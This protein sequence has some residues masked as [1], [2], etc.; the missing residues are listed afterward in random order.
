MVNTELIKEFK[1]ALLFI[2]KFVGLYILLNLAYGIYV[3]SYQTGPDY[4]TQIVTKQT[5]WTLNLLGESTYTEPDNLIPNQYIFTKDMSVLAVFEGCNGLNTM[6]VFVAFLLA[7]GN[8]TKKLLWFVPLGFML[9]HLFNIIRLG[10]LYY[11]VI[12]FEDY[13]YF[14]HKYLFTAFLFLVIF[15]LWVVWVVRIYPSSRED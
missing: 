3:N 9:I 14:T 8:P 10:A 1:P 4:I 5:S 6:I 13:L 7:Y 2:G 15:L 11:V 12:Y